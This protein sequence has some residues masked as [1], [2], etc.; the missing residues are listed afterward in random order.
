MAEALQ[1]SQMLREE[2]RNACIKLRSILPYLQQIAQLAEMG[3]KATPS[4]VDDTAL[5][6]YKAIVNLLEGGLEKVIDSM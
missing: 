2:I 3:V 1:R 5:V 4:D 6:I